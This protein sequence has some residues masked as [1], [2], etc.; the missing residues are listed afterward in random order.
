M[1][2]PTS[3]FSEKEKLANKGEEI[4]VIT[5]KGDNPDALRVVFRILH[6]KHR[7]VKREMGVS[8]VFEVAVL[9]DKYQLEEA[10]LIWVELWASKLEKPLDEFPG[11]LEWM[12][13][14]WLF[15]LK[16]PLREGLER[17]LA[18]AS[19]DA[20]GELVFLVSGAVGEDGKTKKVEKYHF[21][22]RIPPKFT[23]ASPNS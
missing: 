17:L 14:C 22:E 6:G 9:A 12:F 8:E 3:S 21:D 7:L 2:G 10:L 13:V 19:N 1:F 11:C 20:K 18:K 15:Q 5:L 23:G 16:E 4:T